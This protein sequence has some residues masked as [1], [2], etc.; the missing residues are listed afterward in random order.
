MNQEEHNQRVYQI[1][2]DYFQSQGQSPEEIDE[3]ISKLAE[4]VQDPGA[5]LV[6]LGNVLF[7]VLVRGEGAIEFHTVGSEKNPRDLVRDYVDL[8]K[9]LKNIGVTVAYSYASDPQFKRIAKMTGLPW[10]ILDIEVDG[11]PTTAYVLE[12]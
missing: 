11:E 2:Y 5:K 3:S 10:K 1:A 9:Y 12:M 6:H 8:M 7:L 4:A